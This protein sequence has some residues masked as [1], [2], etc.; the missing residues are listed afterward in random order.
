[1][2][3]PAGL[4]LEEADRHARRDPDDPGHDRHRRGE[5]LAVAHPARARVEEGVEVAVLGVLGRVD[6][7]REAAVL[8]EPLLERPRLAEAGGGV[9]GDGGRERAH[10]AGHAGRHLEVGRPHVGGTRDGPVH[11]R[12]VEVERDGREVVG[13]AGRRHLV[14]GAD[15]VHRRGV[16]TPV[17]GRLDVREVG[18]GGQPRRL[19]VGVDAA[20][21]TPTPRAARTGPRRRGRASRPARPGSRGCRGRPGSTCRR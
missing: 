8:A 1:M 14:V 21:G 3:G 5:L 4:R 2:L 17:A 18:R 11:G 16:V 12:A 10:V 6:V 9:A 20:R 19:E 13:L 15:E 7:V